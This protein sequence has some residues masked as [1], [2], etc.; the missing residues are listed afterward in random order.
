M[1]DNVRLHELKSVFFKA[2]LKCPYAP[3]QSSEDAKR[4]FAQESWVHAHILPLLYDPLTF[5]LSVTA[6]V[7]APLGVLAA[8]CFSFCR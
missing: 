4:T 6:S 7:G 3:I 2:R 5:A 8:A 1:V